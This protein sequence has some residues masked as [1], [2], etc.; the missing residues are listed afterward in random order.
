MRGQVDEVGN[1]DLGVEVQVAQHCVA[2]ED[3]A[4]GEIG[5]AGEGGV[6]RVGLGSIGNGA[7]SARGGGEGTVDSLRGGQPA[8]DEVCDGREIG[9]GDDQGIVG[10]V[11]GAE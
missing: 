10:Q 3:F 9:V 1:A 7:H 2:D 5:F 4:A 8:F 11:Q 6:K